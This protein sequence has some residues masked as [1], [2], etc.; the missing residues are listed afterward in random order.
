MYMIE[1]R[2]HMNICAMY[3]LSHG[4]EGTGYFVTRGRE[5]PEGDKLAKRPRGHVIT[6]L[7]QFKTPTLSNHY[8]LSK[9][10]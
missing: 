3:L 6:G 4:H 8:V 7:L 10:D 1:D 2:T 9:R 5:V